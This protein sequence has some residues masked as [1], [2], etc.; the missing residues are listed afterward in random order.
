MQAELPLRRGASDGADAELENSGRGVR[1]PEGM[2][3]AMQAE[4]P[5]RRGASDGADAELE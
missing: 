2:L 1:C 4:L 3:P 5:L